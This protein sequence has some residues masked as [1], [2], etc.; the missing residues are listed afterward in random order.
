M[1][2]GSFRL[3]RVFVYPNRNLISLSKPFLINVC[4]CFRLTIICDNFY[5]VIHFP[6]S[7]KVPD[8]VNFWMGDERAVTSMHKDHYEN[9][10]CVVDGAKTFTLIPPSD[11]PFIPYQLYQT[12]TYKETSPGD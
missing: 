10:Y 11:Q 12:A 1:G 9:L 8:A 2:H 5:I 3:A 6:V 4:R 7:G